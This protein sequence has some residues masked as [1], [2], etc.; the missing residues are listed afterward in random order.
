MFLIS[1]LILSSNELWQF[2]AQLFNNVVNILVLS[3]ILI[4]APNFA[5]NVLN[6]AIYL[7]TLVFKLFNCLLY[8]FYLLTHVWT[9][10]D[11]DQL[12]LKTVYF[13]FNLLKILFCIGIK[14]RCFL[15]H[16]VQLFGKWIEGWARNL[17]AWLRIRRIDCQ[18]DCF[19]FC[20]CRY[21]PL[22]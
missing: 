9:F 4:F 18:F 1:R 5:F 7:F 11:V 17:L 2:I 3:F 10:S 6:F 16:W 14:F 15:F 8:L 20:G 19:H 22:L 13:D 21:F 12:F